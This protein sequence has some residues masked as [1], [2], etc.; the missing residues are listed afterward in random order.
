MSS[1]ASLTANKRNALRSTGPLTA[2]GKRRVSRN[3]LKHGLSTS[4][5]HQP[6]NSAKIEALAVA[7]AGP[8][9]DPVRLQA[10]R[11]VAEAEFELR[12]Q[13]EFRL[14]LVEVEAAKIRV[15]AKVTGD[16]EDAGDR[17]MRDTARAVMQALPHLTKLDRYERRAWASYRRAVH[18]YAKSEGG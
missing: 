2:S 12:R 18:I 7:I 9:S 14:A 16:D 13:R 11:A 10:A 5:R 6:G 1:Q 3:A 15:T 8:N 4:M 17:D